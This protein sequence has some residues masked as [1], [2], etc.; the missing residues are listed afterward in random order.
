MQNTLIA[1]VVYQ[2]NEAF[3]AMQTLWQVVKQLRKEGIKVA[4][5]INKC[6]DD[7][8]AID[9]IIQSI[10]DNR[11]YTILQCLGTDTIGCRLNPTALAESSE[12]LREAILQKPDV[13]F[14]NRFGV[15]ESEGRG[16]LAE[17][18]AAILAGIPVVSLV[19]QKYFLHWQEF[20]AGFGQKLTIDLNQIVNWIKER[21][22]LL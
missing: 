20:S 21:N 17:F 2:D 19:N 16:L 6:D 9:A 10:T 12:V 18:T 3:K 4:G 15:S 8:Q 7:G 14:I 22:N 13:L 5:L 11:K 1:A